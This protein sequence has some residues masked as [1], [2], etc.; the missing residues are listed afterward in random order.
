MYHQP[1]SIGSECPSLPFVRGKRGWG[2]VGGDFGEARDTSETAFD[3]YRA[4]GLLFRHPSLCNAHSHP[5]T[6]S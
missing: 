4:R 1:E 3:V 5:P 2:G 6:H